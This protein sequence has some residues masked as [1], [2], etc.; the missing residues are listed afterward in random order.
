MVKTYHCLCSSNQVYMKRN[1][2]GNAQICG[3]AGKLNWSS[4]GK[5]MMLAV[6]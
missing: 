2:V 1:S 6:S 4:S 3:V 5:M